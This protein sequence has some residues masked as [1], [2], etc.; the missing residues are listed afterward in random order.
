[1]RVVLI[2][3]VLNVVSSMFMRYQGFIVAKGL[4]HQQWTQW[5]VFVVSH[6]TT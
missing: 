6:S 4:L 1:M 3:V 5:Y 2:M